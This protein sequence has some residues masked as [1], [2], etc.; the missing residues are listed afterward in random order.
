[1]EEKKKIILLVVIVV[2][3]LS[4]AISLAGLFIVQASNNTDDNEMRTLTIKVLGNGTTNPL[5]GDYEIEKGKTIKIAA[6]PGAD[7]FL[8]CWTGIMTAYDQEISIPVKEDCEITANFKKTPV[9]NYTLTINVTGEGATIPG[10]GSRKYA[11]GTIVNL[12]AV[13]TSPGS[14]FDRWTGPVNTTEKTFSIVML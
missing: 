14:I 10:K 5:P 6:L 9:I 12:T 4:T 8:D 13:E 11:A 7:S 3:V 1:M 2:T